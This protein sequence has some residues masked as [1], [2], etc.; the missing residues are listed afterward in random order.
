MLSKDISGAQISPGDSLT[1]PENEE[2][3]I[4]ATLQHVCPFLSLLTSYL[5][6]IAGKHFS[7]YRCST[8][9]IFLKRLKVSVYVST[10][11][12]SQQTC[13]LPAVRYYEFKVFSLSK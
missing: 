8:L 1:E 4:I 9:G 6:H 7:K 3:P 10:H 11:G 5:P 2:D 13:L 12:A